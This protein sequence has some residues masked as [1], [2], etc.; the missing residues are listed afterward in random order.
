MIDG[1]ELSHQQDPRKEKEVWEKGELTSGQH[2][3]GQPR[4]TQHAAA[5]LDLAFRTD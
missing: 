4:T 3:T 2:R 1:R 5:G